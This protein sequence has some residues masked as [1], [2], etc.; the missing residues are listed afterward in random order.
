MGW[1]IVFPRKMLLFGCCTDML[2]DPLNDMKILLNP[3]SMSEI[4]HCYESVQGLLPFLS[5]FFIANGYTVI[6]QVLSPVTSAATL[7]HSI[8][9]P[10][11]IDEDQS[12]H[13]LY[14]YGGHVRG[15]TTMMMLPLFRPS[16]G[17]ISK[18]LAGYTYFCTSQYKTNRRISRS[19]N[20]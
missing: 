4:Q 1:S 19:D 8:T 7:T 18:Q 2:L 12:Q 13:L 15:S 14:L 17:A 10:H 9:S 5:L 6:D 3:T 16:L 11:A 20:R